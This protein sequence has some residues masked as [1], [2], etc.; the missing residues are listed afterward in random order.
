MSDILDDLQS[1]ADAEGQVSLGDVVEKIGPRGRG[2]LLLLPGLLGATPV[3]A[4]PGVPTILG[5]FTILI[6]LQIV[7]QRS[8][9]WLPG[10][11]R[12]RSV[13]DGKLSSAISKSRGPARWID[14][15]FGKRLQVLTQ[16]PATT[17]AALFCIALGAILPPLEVV[18]FAALLPFAAIALLG[19]A[20]TLRDGLLMAVAFA[21][22]GGALYGAWTLAF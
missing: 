1:L 18:P 5:L 19:I 13:S 8:K 11:I 7:M 10:F 14:R 9:L 16:Q 4:I 21:A 12:R 22:S 6:A 3:G 2:A 15:H 17:I 20:L